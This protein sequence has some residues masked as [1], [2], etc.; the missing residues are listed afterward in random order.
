VA[1]VVIGRHVLAA[2]PAPAG[3]RACPRAPDQ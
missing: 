3:Q 1:V 2:G